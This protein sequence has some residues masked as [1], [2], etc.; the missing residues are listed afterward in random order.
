MVCCKL[1]HEEELQQKI[2]VQMLF[3]RRHDD[4]IATVKG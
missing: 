1:F 3:C 4:K 2:L